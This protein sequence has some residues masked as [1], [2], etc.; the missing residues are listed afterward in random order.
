[1]NIIVISGRLTKKPE[2][3][4]TQSLKHV[5]QFSLAVDNNRV[6][7]NGKRGVDFI[8]CVCFDKQ[9]ENLVK[10]KNKGD[11]IELKGKI[12]NDRYTNKDGKNVSRTMIYAET[13]NY[14]SSTQTSVSTSKNDEK[15]VYKDFGNR[16]MNDND[17]QL[18]F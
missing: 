2:L 10:Y 13:I 11:F 12:Q 4:T 9:A 18:P 3:R 14:I 15:D 1:M 6:D 17:Y 16:V 5:C 8:E 7:E